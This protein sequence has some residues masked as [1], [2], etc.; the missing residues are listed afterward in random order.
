MQVAGRNAVTQLTDEQRTERC[1][2]ARKMWG[3][4]THSKEWSEVRQCVDSL[5][6]Q[7]LI[8]VTLLIEMFN[9]PERHPEVLDLLFEEYLNRKLI[10]DFT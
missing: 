4:K 10:G 8:A 6:D 9:N 7:G 3:A 5:V 1:A 2:W